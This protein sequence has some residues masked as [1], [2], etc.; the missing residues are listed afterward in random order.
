MSC[1]V[2]F[3]IL[4][5]FI[6]MFVLVFGVS[7][8]AEFGGLVLKD[9]KHWETYGEGGTCISG[10]HNLFIADVDDDGVLEVLTGGF[11]YNIVNGERT[12]SLAPLKIWNWTGDKLVLEKNHYWD[13]NIRCIFCEDI[14]GDGVMEILTGGTVLGD[15]GSFYSIR[16]W[17]YDG[18]DVVLEGSYNDVSVNCIFVSDLDK[19]GEFEILTTGRASYNVQSVAQLQVWGWK[20]NTISLLDSVEWCG[21]DDARANSVYAYDLNNDNEIEIVTVG[22]DNGLKNSS[23]QLRIWSWDGKSLLLKANQEWRMVEN[24]YGLTNAGGVM[25]NTLVK[26]LKVGDVD[27]DGSAEIV[28]GGFTYDGEKINAQ[29]RVWYYGATLSLEKSYEWTTEDITTVEVLSLN[30]ID[31][32]GVL[33][34]VTGGLTSVY[35]SFK[36][37]DA[38]RDAAQLR[39]LGWDGK[40]FT[41]K[42]EADWTIADG[43]AVMNVGADDLDNDGKHEIVSVGCMTID[44]LCDPDMRIWSLEGVVAD[45]NFFYWV[46]LGVILAVVVFGLL[47]YFRKKSRNSGSKRIDSE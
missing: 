17:H 22:Y 10:S 27:S 3:R 8:R 37:L 36:N 31:N 23:G 39:V 11:M 44:T 42:Q 41:L 7:V 5:F 24:C 18:V 28:T 9:E 2:R 15:S 4:L 32:D 14:D 13:G 25:G 38:P 20:D 43:V 30:D 34:I 29:I 12:T 35:G 47:F 26:N 19:N 45:F 40:E 6:V 46:A 16:V 1:S 21:S 33:D